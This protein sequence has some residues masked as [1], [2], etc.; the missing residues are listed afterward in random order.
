[1][2]RNPRRYIL[3]ERN[4]ACLRKRITCAGASSTTS[5]VRVIGSDDSRDAR[6]RAKARRQGGGAGSKGGRLLFEE[7]VEEFDD[8][9]FEASEDSML[10]EAGDTSPFDRELASSKGGDNAYRA[11]SARK[12]K[13]GNIVYLSN[14]AYP[15]VWY[16]ILA[17]NDSRCVEIEAFR[18]PG[19]DVN[20][21]L[22]G[23]K[24]GFLMK[25]VTRAKRGQKKKTTATV[26]G[27]SGVVVSTETGGKGKGKGGYSRRD[28]RHRH[29]A[30]SKGFEIDSK[31]GPVVTG[32]S[33]AVATK[34]RKEKAQIAGYYYQKDVTRNVKVRKLPSRLCAK[35]AAVYICEGD[36][37]TS[38]YRNKSGKRLGRRGKRRTPLDD[39][40][41][42]QNQMSNRFTFPSLSGRLSKRKRRGRPADKM[43]LR[44]REK[45]T[46]TPGMFDGFQMKRKRNG[47]TTRF[48]VAALCEMR[49]EKVVTLS[50]FSAACA[51]TGDEGDEDKNVGLD[52]PDLFPL[53]EPGEP[54]TQ[55]DLNLLQGWPPAWQFPEGEV[56]TSVEASPPNM[57]NR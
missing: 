32:Q 29:L 2:V 24:G 41:V 7:G 18:C 53:L 1:M 26:V 52:D 23:P 6:P 25:V 43:R 12:F 56:C 30:E 5:A 20:T 3:S 17:D 19:D 35:T 34:T 46:V 49:A 39:F 28:S 51:T 16:D 47:R 21:P 31:A 33:V 22:R 55:D 14:D 38:G 57:P 8:E 36:T 48:N 37:L 45:G 13:N 27:Q 40:L 44:N 54:L 50:K 42:C 4:P 10:Q 11:G 15:D 9:S